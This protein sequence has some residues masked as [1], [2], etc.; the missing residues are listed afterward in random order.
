[1][2]SV[3]CRNQP[4]IKL[5]KMTFA[6]NIIIDMATVPFS[7]KMAGK[8]QSAHNIPIRRFIFIQ[9]IFLN[10]LNKNPRHPIS[11]KNAATTTKGT[12]DK[13]AKEELPN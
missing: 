4:N 1:M 10:A 7:V 5:S 13:N 8:C 12:L 3:F 2:P 6:V 9:P 11:S